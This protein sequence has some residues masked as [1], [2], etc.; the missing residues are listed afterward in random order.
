MRVPVIKI[1]LSE[2]DSDRKSIADRANNARDAVKL[3]RALRAQK[4]LDEFN[5]VETA[6]PTE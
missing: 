6:S 2:K 3:R 5:A 1:S 4:I